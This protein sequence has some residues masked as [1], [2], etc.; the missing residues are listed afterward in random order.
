VENECW[1]A[2][3]SPAENKGDRPPIRVRDNPLDSGGRALYLT[4]KLINRRVNHRA[5]RTVP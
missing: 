3:G 2:Q 4:N 1:R 5:H